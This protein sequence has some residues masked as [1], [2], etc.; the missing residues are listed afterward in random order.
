MQDRTYKFKRLVDGEYVDFREEVT[1]VSTVPLTFL[2]F[3]DIDDILKFSNEYQRIV[4]P[5]SIISLTNDLL[6]R[7]NL[8]SL[9]EEFYTF[10]CGAQKEFSTYYLAKD[11]EPLLE[12]FMEEGKSLKE[13]LQVLEK[14]LFADN[15]KWLKSIRFDN[16]Q[17]LTIENEDVIP[18]PAPL[19]INHF[20][21]ITTIY[22]AICT[23]LNLNKENFQE[24]KRELLLQTNSFNYRMAA[25][26]IRKN[27]TEAL[28]S[29]VYPDLIPG[30]NNALTFVGLCLHSSQIPYKKNEENIELDVKLGLDYNLRSIEFKNIQNI[31]NRPV[32]T[33]L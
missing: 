6:A 23:G 7:Y 21:T 4:L 30:K 27:I 3:D 19:K 8:S 32:D 33:E 31:I 29:F 2:K 17:W 11:E 15:R 22:D 24:R 28:F 1:S 20:F 13:L 12:D 14:F 18:E 5:T 16:D 10:L 25:R 26:K 9:Q